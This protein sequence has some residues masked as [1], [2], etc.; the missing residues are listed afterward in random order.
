MPRGK[1][2]ALLSGGLDSLLATRLIIDQGIEVIG[3]HFITPFFGYHQKGREGEF[4]NQWRQRHGLEVRIL[5]VSEG[6]FQILRHPRY[7]Y[8][9]HFNP[10][11]DCKIFL[12]SQAREWMEKEGADF[13]ISGEVLGQRPMSQRRDTMRIVERE[14]KT[15][16]ILLRP[17]CAKNLK[18]TQP[19]LSGVVDREKLLGISGRGRKPQIELARKMGIQDYPTPAG[20][21]LLTDP[22]LSQR[23]RQYFREHPNVEV[24][25]ILL[26]LVGRHFRLPGGGHLIIGRKEAENERIQRLAQRGEILLRLRA[27]PG[28]LGLIRGPVDEVSLRLA[29]SILARYSKARGAAEVEVRYGRNPDGGD[30]ILSVAP[31]RD[32]I[33]DLLRFESFPEV[34]PSS[35]GDEGRGF[36]S[37]PNGD[38]K[39]SG[40]REDSRFGFAAPG[41]SGGSLDE[42]PL[43]AAREDPH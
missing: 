37:V 19:E 34:P 5:D 4:Q 38:R 36:G 17:L 7:G 6:F 13:L 22:I 3:L 35:A 9:K 21:C 31:A 40:A 41:L 28:P 15:E 39:N 23:I 8:G 43:G 18:P 12:F 30:G 27:I 2:I 25:E 1:A 42:G 29:G 14:S 16:G 26:L 20:G 10:C 24:R 11:I 33:L 32:E